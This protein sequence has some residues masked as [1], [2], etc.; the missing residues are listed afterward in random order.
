M[1]DDRPED[2]GFRVVDRRVF[3]PDGTRREVPAEEVNDEK[4]EKQAAPASPAPQA[5]SARAAQPAAEEEVAELPEGAFETL[6]SYLS[7][8]ALFQL[9]LLEGP[10]GDRI[11]PDLPNARRT[12]DLIEVLKHK[13][14]GNLTANE[15]RFLDQVLYELQM[16]YV[17]IERHAA[18]RGK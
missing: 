9:G 5:A 15:S 8:T 11:P 18:R 14:R 6:V 1:A 12:I 17:E 7:T 4:D 2:Q 13:T 3:S 10:G 16:S